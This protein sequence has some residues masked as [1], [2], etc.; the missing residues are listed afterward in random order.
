MFYLHESIPDPNMAKGTSIYV[1]AKMESTN[2]F[3]FSSI[4]QPMCSRE[5]EENLVQSYSALLTAGNEQEGLQM[6]L[7]RS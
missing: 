6:S 3:T 1:Q 5:Y 2:S 7:D 4:V